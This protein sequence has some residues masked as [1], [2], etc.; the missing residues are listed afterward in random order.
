MCG[1]AGIINGGNRETLERMAGVQ[2]HR[3]P[4]DWGAQWFA[5]QG[6]GLAH[7]RL[8]IID[9]S[10][11]G[12]QPMSNRT[13]NR[14]ITFNGEIY[15]YLELR[16][17]LR[18]KGYTFASSSDTEVILAAYDEWGPRC[19]ERLNGMFAFGIY[20]TSTA[21][22]FIARDHLGIKPLYYL[23]R[24]GMF[25]FA[26]E[27][28]ALFEI[29]GVERRVNFDA[30]ASTLLFLWVPEPESGFEDVM[31]LEAGHYATFSHGRLSIT[32]YW[33]IP[34]HESRAV[35]ERSESEYAE[36]LREILE[37]VIR[38][39]M[40]ADVPVGAFLSGGLD[41]SLIVALM[42]KVTSGPISTYTIAFS[43]RDKK[44]E[45]MPDDARYAAIVAKHFATEHHEIEADPDINRLLPKML[46]HL[47][48]PIADGASI[49]TYLIAKGAKARGTTVLLNGMG[50]DEVFGGYRRQLATLLIGNYQRIPGVVRRQLIERVA[51]MLPVAIGGRGIRITRWAKKFLRSASLPALE[52]FIHGFAYFNP[53]ELRQLLVAPYNA[54]PF[55]ELYPIRR[56]REA[57]KRVE[58][59]PLIDRMTYLDTKMFLPGL[60]LTYS[61]KAAMAA[62]VETR[63]PLID[64]ELVEFAARLPARYKINGRVQKYLLK[65]V[66]EAYLPHEIIYRPKAPFGTP[67]RAWMKSG[68]DEQ[69]N[70]RFSDPGF[71]ANGFLR[72]EL[73]LKLLAEHKSGSEDH[74]H[75][76][77]GVYALSTWLELQKEEAEESVGGIGRLD[78]VE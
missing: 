7:R 76:L 64:I 19:V 47:D 43:E 51:E 73:P 52:A 29:E 41:S 78:G 65:R 28:K 67:I 62:S 38:R 75:R 57:A 1:I 55:E 23:H 70:A 10:P 40:I 13:G 35:R 32:Q 31:K 71:K 72:P 6:S 63:P 49:N 45:A 50:G 48:D 21:E 30:V 25:A 5:E 11:A 39:Q 26:S 44:M 37:R 12:H 15:N 4:D 68:L 2:A 66:A 14:W 36:E 58:G 69:V 18:A 17:E 77:W 34:V 56:Y 27:A 8:S 53:D 61:D 46:W 59:L 3:G 54:I 33:D 9:L 20:D 16:E 24:N 60:N 74:A 42:R 22:L